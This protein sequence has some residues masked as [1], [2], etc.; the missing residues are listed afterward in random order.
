MRIGVVSDTHGLVRPEVKDAL[1]GCDIILHAGDINHQGILDELG[2]IAPV[3]VVRGNNDTAWAAHIP[4]TL[5]L[6]LGG[7]R[8]CMSHMKR[9]LP[10]DLTPYD[11]VVLGHTHK[12]S[13][14]KQGHTTFLN[15]GSCGPRRF[16]QA[17]TMASI[18]IIDDEVVIRRIDISSHHEANRVRSHASPS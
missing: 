15:P 12:Y 7:L 5:D 11:L 2:T 6:E 17:I 8:I 9:D 3:K 10:A 4:F 14:T 13:E 18:D 16:G 1:R